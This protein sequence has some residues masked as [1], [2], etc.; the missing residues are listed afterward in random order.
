[1]L[2]RRLAALVSS[3]LTFLVV[4]ATAALANSGADYP[5]SVGGTGTEV[6]GTV[7]PNSDVANSGGGLP[8]T[9]FEVGLLVTALVLV[10]LGAVLVVASR[11]RQRVLAL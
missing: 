2:V 11:R 5:P 3:V 1:V 6:E 4:G 10:A 9:G 7:I 8:H